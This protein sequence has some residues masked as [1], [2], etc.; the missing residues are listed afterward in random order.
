MESMSGCHLQGNRTWL[1]RSYL[2][3]LSGSSIRNSGTYSLGVTQLEASLLS[4]WDMPHIG[5][6]IGVFVAP[7]IKKSA[8][9]WQL[10]RNKSRDWRKDREMHSIFTVGLWLHSDRGCSRFI[11]EL[12][13]CSTLV[14]VVTAKKQREHTA[15]WYAYYWVYSPWVS[16][17]L[18]QSQPFS[19]WNFWQVLGD[20]NFI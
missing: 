13:V 18:L 7:M 2:L 1:V 6:I 8:W 5:H 20:G 4:G 14:I 11:K 3:L 15:N 12:D 19:S 17:D 9:R 10:R 16:G